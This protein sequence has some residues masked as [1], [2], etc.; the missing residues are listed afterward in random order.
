MCVVGGGDVHLLVLVTRLR[1]FFFLHKNRMQNHFFFHSFLYS[2]YTCIPIIYPQGCNKKAYQKHG[3][4]VHYSLNKNM[5][6]YN[7]QFFNDTCTQTFCLHSFIQIIQH[8][9]LSAAICYM[10]NKFNKTP[11][12]T[13]YFVKIINRPA[14][15]GRNEKNRKVVYTMQLVN[16][17]N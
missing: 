5:H 1:S 2:N 9:T 8:L 7:S 4:S 16:E 17:K 3:N 14:F 13:V 11:A 10:Y 15:S 12:G 6:R